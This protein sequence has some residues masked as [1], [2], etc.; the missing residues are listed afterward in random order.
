MSAP[1]IAGILQM[2]SMKC[3][4]FDKVVRRTFYPRVNASGGGATN[5]LNIFEQPAGQW[6]KTGQDVPHLSLN[7]ILD[8]FAVNTTSSFVARYIFKI[9]MDA[10]DCV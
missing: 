5:A 6:V 8:Q 9:Y 7:I 3:D 1:T 2:D 4:R 10:K